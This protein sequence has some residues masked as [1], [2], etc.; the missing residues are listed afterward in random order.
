MTVPENGFRFINCRPLS[1][2][3]DGY[4]YR[5]K[6]QLDSMMKGRVSKYI[7]QGLDLLRKGSLLHCLILFYCQS[8]LK[9]LATILND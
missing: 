3:N 5:F 6:F 4:Y 7:L 8:H 2:Q 1:Y 9:H